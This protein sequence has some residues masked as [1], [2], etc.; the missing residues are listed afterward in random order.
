MRQPIFL[1]H[2]DV[3]SKKVY[4]CAPQLDEQL[5][6]SLRNADAKS[7]TVHISTRQVLPATAPELVKTLSD[8]HLVFANREMTSAS[9]SSFSH[10][11]NDIHDQDLHFNAL[12]AK[13]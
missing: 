8:I 5:A 11:L 12:Q 2:A 9:N 13:M 6:A 3:I 7:V 10:S 4:W 1:S